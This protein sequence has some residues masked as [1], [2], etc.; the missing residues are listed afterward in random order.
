MMPRPRSQLHLQLGQE[1]IYV[2]MALGIMTSL[3][4]LAKAE[5]VQAPQRFTQPSPA[6]PEC[7]LPERGP[8]YG[9][10]DLP[11]CMQ[12]ER[13]CMAAVKLPPCMQ[14]KNCISAQDNKPPILSLTEQRGFKFAS[15]SYVIDQD[16]KT[17]L[18]NEIVPS[19]LKLSDELG[20]RVIEIV[21]Y[22]DGV[23]VSQDRKSTLDQKLNP[24]LSGD[25]TLSGDKALSMV[26]NVGLGMMR[27]A[28]V[29]RA[30]EE[31]EQLQ[32]RGFTFLAMS[33][34]QTI[35]PDD[36]P[37]GAESGKAAGDEKR[38]R[39]EIRLRRPLYET[40]QEKAH[41]AKTD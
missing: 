38:R 36:R 12:T 24:Y 6:P 9:P 29:V 39:I 4:L 22:T 15:G 17:K 26:D 16:F 8:C 5:R 37:V 35:G 32:K 11:P 19:I 27:A 10:R 1:V 23:P 30:L 7:A 34:G 41:Q 33:A 31:M 3:I 21:G 13:G 18:Q 20:A 2:L 28:A 14:A 25:K 40:D